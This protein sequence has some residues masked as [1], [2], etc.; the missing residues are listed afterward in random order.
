MRVCRNVSISKELE[1]FVV[2]LVRSGRYGSASEVVRAA[3]RMLQAQE[4]PGPAA[5]SD[6]P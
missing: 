5:K 4:E 2:D 3:L 6:A 1:R